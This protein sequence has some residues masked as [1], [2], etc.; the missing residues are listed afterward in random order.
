LQK[1]LSNLSQRPEAADYAD[2]R[3]QLDATLER[4]EGQ[5]GKAVA[6]ADPAGLSE[7]ESENSFRLLG[8][9]RGVS[10]AL[11]NF[12]QQVRGIDWV[13]LREERF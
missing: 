7:R 11:V 5:I 13:H 12:A 4:L 2:L 3:A 6:G 10:E 9:L 1:I 8:A